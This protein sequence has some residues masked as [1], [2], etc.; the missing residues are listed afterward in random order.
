MDDCPTQF[1]ECEKHFDRVHEQ[2]KQIDEAIR[3]NGT[4]GINVR[5]DRL[6][7]DSTRRSRLVWAVVGATATAVVSAVVPVLV[8]V[9][10]TGG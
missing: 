6:E 9:L 8:A 7:Q 5:L 3:G 2:L 1:D 4:P 10:R